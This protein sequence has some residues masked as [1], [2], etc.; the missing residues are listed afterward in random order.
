MT[1]WNSYE[2]QLRKVKKWVEEL[3]TVDLGGTNGAEAGVKSEF[4]HKKTSVL[5]MEV[6]QEFI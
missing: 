4:S 3:W 6:A 2:E 5:L 1:K